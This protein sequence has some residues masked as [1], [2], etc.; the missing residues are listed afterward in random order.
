MNWYGTAGSGTQTPAG[1]RAGD[2][3]SMCGNAVM[4]QAIAGKILTVGGSPDYSGKGIGSPT[5]ECRNTMFLQIQIQNAP[6]PPTVRQNPFD[7]RNIQAVYSI[8]TFDRFHRNCERAHNQHRQTQHEPSGKTDRLHGLPSRLRQQRSS[9]RWPSTRS[10]WAISRHSF[11]R[12][13][14]AIH[15]RALESGFKEIQTNGA[16]VYS[17]KLSVSLLE[18]HFNPASSRKSL[19]IKESP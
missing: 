3:D 11:H 18:F 2:P 19:Q 9:S 1:N 4:C 6:F 16:N 17:K 10:R 7:C 8:L 14:R 13:H 5:R 12:R 15:T